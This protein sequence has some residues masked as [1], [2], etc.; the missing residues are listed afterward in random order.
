MYTYTATL[1]EQNIQNLLNFPC[2]N[3]RREEQFIREAG[4]SYLFCL[5]LL[6]WRILSEVPNNQFDSSGGVAI[7]LL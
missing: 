3:E 4:V 7:A 1:L 2:E 6:Q 5:C